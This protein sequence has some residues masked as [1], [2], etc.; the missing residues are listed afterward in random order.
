M[1][2][3]ELG[4]YMRITL[5][6]QV[7]AG[8]ERVTA[9]SCKATMLAWLAKAGVRRSDRRMLGY[10]STRSD[11]SMLEYSRDAMPGPLRKLAKVIDDVRCRRFFPDETR[12]GRYA[13]VEASEACGSQGPL[14]QGIKRDADAMKETDDIVYQVVKKKFHR[15]GRAGHPLCGRKLTK[16]YMVKKAPSKGARV[17]RCGACFPSA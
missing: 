8:L 16:L 9:H 12:S 5:K 15:K 13:A 10:H 17:A 6:V 1:T 2:S 14:P 7:P 3:A 4:N 11:S